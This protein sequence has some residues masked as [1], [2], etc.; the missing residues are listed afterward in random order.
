MK[1]TSKI[2]LLRYCNREGRTA[3][4]GVEGVHRDTLDSENVVAVGKGRSSSRIAVA[5]NP[6]HITV[7]KNNFLLKKNTDEYNEG[8]GHTHES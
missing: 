7:S 6:G 2:R 8:H 5:L 4:R 3:L 1:N